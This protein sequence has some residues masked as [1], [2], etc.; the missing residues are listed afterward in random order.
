MAYVFADFDKY[1]NLDYVTAWYKKALDFIQ[2]TTIEVC[3]VSTNSI[4]QGESVGLLWGQLNQRYD[5]SINFAHQSFKW[6]NE[7]RNNAGVYVIIV[8]FSLNEREN[9][10]LFIYDSPTSIP[11]SIK[12][13][14]INS[15]LVDYEEVNISRI[16]K[17][18]CDVPKMQWGVQPRD[19]GNLLLTP[20]ERQDLLEKEPL[21][22]KWIKP[23][24]SAKEFLNNEERYCLWLE[25][26]TPNELLN[27]PE[28]KNRVEKVRLFRLKSKAESTRKFAEYPTLFAQRNNPKTDYILVPISTSENRDYIP[29]SFVSKNVIPNNSIS[30][31]P[32]DDKYIMGV[33]MSK[34]HMTWMSYVCGRLKGDFRYSAT[35]VYNNYPFP[36][37]IGDNRRED[38]IS[39]VHYILDVR[40]EFP[41]ESLANLYDPI[42]MPP[43]LK[44]AHLKL[45]NSVDKSYRS[46]KFKDNRDR[47]KYLFD[48]YL[49]YSSKLM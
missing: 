38:I 1:K 30:L 5:F 42:L 14:N 43:E 26:I 7:A 40:D 25:G 39:K 48:L 9:K 18:I 8:G 44:K 2:G 17:P 3:F 12:V 47:I 46:K 21:A 36:N 31:I 13:N 20:K 32:S 4:C 37:K 10:T 24:A 11:Y 41:N 22:E 19:D 33:I 15:Y 27:L 45:D 35:L 34:M 29:I 49:D 23:L 6:T 16:S 28:V